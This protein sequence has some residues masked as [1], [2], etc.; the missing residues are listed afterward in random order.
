MARIGGLPRDRKP[1]VLTPRRRAHNKSETPGADNEAA[2]PPLDV[3]RRRA[4]A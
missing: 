1:T 2:L 3:A 4:A